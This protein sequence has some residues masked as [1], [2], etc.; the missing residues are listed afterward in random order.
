MQVWETWCW[1]IDRMLPEDVGEGVALWIW[2]VE[3]SLGR[4]VGNR[5][6]GEGLGAWRPAGS[7][8]SQESSGK[9]L[10]TVARSA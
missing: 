4:C 8:P 10:Y 7:S 5:L 3:R 9:S 1:V 2:N 6:V